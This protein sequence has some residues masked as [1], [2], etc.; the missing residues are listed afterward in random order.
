M[1]K[2]DSKGQVICEDVYGYSRK[3]KD[4]YINNNNKCI[5][6]SLVVE[7]YADTGHLIFYRDGDDPTVLINSPYIAGCIMKRLR[8][9]SINNW[10]L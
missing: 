5:P 2:Y 9:I 4:E 6:E 7:F 8:A 10:S 3:Y 1:P